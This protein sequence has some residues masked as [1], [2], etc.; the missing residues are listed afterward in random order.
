MDSPA[1]CS[2]QLL[3]LLL[4]FACFIVSSSLQSFDAPDAGAA[5]NW[6]PPRFSFSFNFSNESSYD[7]HDLRFEGDATRHGKLIDLTYDS[8]MGNMKA[9]QG[10]M[11]YA[12][13]VP[14]YDNTTGEVAC[15]STRFTFKILYDN[16]TANNRGDGM[17]F[18][19]SGYPSRLPVSS[20]GA[21][22]GLVSGKPLSANGADQFVAVEFDTFSNR[23]WDPNTFDHIGIDI[24]SIESV[25]TTSLPRFTLNGSMTATI[26]FHNTTRKLVASLQFDD[27]PS[28]HPVEVST[29]LPNT[30]SI[31]YWLPPEVA[32]GF[33]ASTGRAIELHQMLA[34]SFNSTLAPAPPK[35]H[36]KKAEVIGGASV[37]LV[38]SLLVVWFILSYWKLKSRRRAFEKQGTGGPRRFEYRDL[39]SAT[40]NFSTEL[41]EG[42]FGKVYRGSLK[43]LGCE[44]AVKI[45]NESRLG[46]GKDF[47]AEIN[48]ISEAKHRN[49]VKL[50]GWCRQN[51]WSIVDFLCWCRQNKSD[52]LCLV[53]E[54]VPNGTLEEHL[55]NRDHVLP[56]ATRY[57][58]VID[59]GYALVYLHEECH[60]CILHRDI[61]PSNI[62]LDNDFNAKLGDFGLSRIVEHGKSKVLTIPIGTEGYLDPQCK[63]P[64][65]MVEFRPSS[66][67]YS[68]GIVLLEIV[69]C[70][71]G[72]VRE[73]VWQW[74]MYNSLLQAAD[75]RLEGNFDSSQMERVIIL[76]LWCSFSDDT[77]RPT[78]RQAMDVLQH[79][80]PLPDLISLDTSSAP[81]ELDAGIDQEAPWSADS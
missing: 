57:K 25:N 51:S 3:F 9:S 14:F 59:I 28:T 62:L 80:K 36:D 63:K 38:L 39:V 72:M 33:S 46:G 11:S 58:I 54:L 77:K 56:W 19:L 68:F 34:W 44:V 13:A 41:G 42:A 45:L 60:P 2:E 76:G 16:D 53:Y 78:I 27:H 32:V 64:V 75:D 21:N 71:T 22:L 79:G 31:R 35:G 24:G 6:P 12:H 37:A 20:G 4:M 40:N 49:L 5:A 70:K 66:D 29:A 74:Y 48:T 26:R 8:S 61:K 81:T 52:K 47:F 7:T 65:G 23:K 69:A 43:N 18:F 50:V 15:F 1:S 30:S 10:R 17:A 73:Q 67:V 55:Y